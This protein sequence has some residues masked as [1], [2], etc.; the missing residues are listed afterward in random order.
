MNSFPSDI[1]EHLPIT[2]SRIAECLKEGHERDTFLTGIIPVAAGAMP[3]ARFKYG[4]H[5]ISL[6][7]YTAVIAPAGSGKGKF[8]IAK[9]CGR[10][11][12]ERLYEESRRR[13]EEWEREQQMGEEDLGPRPQE[14]TFFLPGDTSAAAMKKHLKANPHSVMF[15]TEFKTVGTVLTQE[16]GQF[17]DVMLKA[18]H[19]ESVTSSR[20]GED[21]LRIGHPALSAAISGTPSTFSEIIE[22]VEDGLYSRFLLYSFRS[23]AE[24][25]P[26]FQDETDEKLDDAVEAAS[27]RLDSLHRQL[28]DRGEPLYID[29]PKA[30]REQHTKACRAAFSTVKESDVSEVL[31]AN[32]KRSGLAALR[33]AAV[34]SILRRDE[35]GARLSNAKSVEISET[36]LYVGLVLAFGFL[37]HAIEI[38]EDL[39]G[40]NELKGLSEE[41]RRYL[42]ELPGGAFDTSEA[43]EIA[44]DMGIYDRKAQRWRRKFADRGL[45]IDAGYGSW[46]RPSPQST[47]GSI[48]LCSIARMV[49]DDRNNLHDTPHV[50]GQDT[51]PD[52]VQETAPF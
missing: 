40:D 29:F 39:E 48:S 46:R 44:S 12:D 10:K 18:A 34:F 30:R 43:D 15:E 52:A 38:A 11:L 36:D 9:E 19:N 22:D 5:W 1:Y 50:E 32:V 4:G 8:R 35:L 3:N 17:G 37:S 42:D 33:I 6:N 23:E 16:W 13:I 28:A 20:S 26:Q 27:K 7:I 14:R 51:Q 41:Q 24:W 21:L 47:D 45:L 49:F 2:I 25:V 31:Y